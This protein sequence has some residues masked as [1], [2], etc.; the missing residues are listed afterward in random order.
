MGD[1]ENQGCLKPRSNGQPTILMELRDFTLGGNF[2]R[3][4]AAFVLALALEKLIKQFVASW[5]TPIIGII[6]GT[7]FADLTFSINSSKF[8]Y[9]LFFD[10][11]ISFSTFLVAF[12]T[13]NCNTNVELQS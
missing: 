2:I 6:G 12:R 13:S 7:S 4:A 5:I 3:I 8:A 1:A 9:G 11:L 10:A